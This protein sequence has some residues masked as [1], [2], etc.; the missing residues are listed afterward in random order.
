MV[1]LKLCVAYEEAISKKNVAE[2]EALFMPQAL[3]ESP[4]L[5]TT[6]VIQ[7]HDFIFSIATKLVIKLGLS[8]RKTSASTIKTPF[9]YM[10]SIRNG[11]VAVLDG[12]VCFEIDK[13]L[14]KFKKMVV[15]Y[16]ARDLRRLLGEAGIEPITES[17]LI[18]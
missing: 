10:F 9:S 7:F 4:I 8:H 14:Q 11:G 2:I 18:A 6:G 1:F 17:P 15:I 5:G 13:S 3:V 12:V 16:D